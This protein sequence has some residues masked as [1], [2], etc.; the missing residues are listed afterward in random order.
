[1][2]CVFCSPSLRHRRHFVERLALLRR[3]LPRRIHEDARDVA[4]GP[5]EPE[6]RG[7][8]ARRA[9]R[10]GEMWQLASEA[11]YVAGNRPKFGIGERDSLAENFPSRADASARGTEIGAI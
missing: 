3:H 6:N 11:R 5:G 7:L 8:D 1:M 9:I 4:G 2:T 10:H